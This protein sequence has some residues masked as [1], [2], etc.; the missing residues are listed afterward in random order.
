MAMCSFV[1]YF[2][3]FHFML[4]LATPVDK[5][6]NVY[7]YQSSFGGYLFIAVGSDCLLRSFMVILFLELS[8]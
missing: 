7:N 3:S 8:N 1:A 2:E 4:N 5:S 6:I